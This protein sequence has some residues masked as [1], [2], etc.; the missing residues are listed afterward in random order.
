MRPAA[1]LRRADGDP[2]HRA[3]RPTRTRSSPRR[4]RA[5]APASRRA[6]VARRAAASSLASGRC[7]AA[8][9]SFRLLFGSH[10]VSGL[11]T[12][13]AVDRAHASTSTTGPTRATW[14]SALL[15]ADFLPGGRDRAAARPARRPALAEAAAVGADLVRL[16]VFVAARL[17]GHAG[18]IV[19]LALVAGR[20]HRLRP[21]G[22]LRRAAE[23][24]LRRATSRAR[25]RCC[26]LA[27]Q[28]TIMVGTLLGGVDRRRCPGRI[29]PTGSTRSASGSR[30][31]CSLRIPRGAAPAGP[32]REP[33]ATGRTSGEGFRLVL[34][35]RPLLAVLV[36]WNLAMIAIAFVER[37]RGLPREGLVRRRRLRL[38]PAVGGERPRRGDRR[39]V[40]VHLARAARA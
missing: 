24:R 25:T 6:N 10:L 8:S 1:R 7:S 5:R 39:A 31:C 32:S 33:R 13:L 36:S 38:R 17:R 20:R 11:G 29:S 23:P 16:A 37:V 12:W 2:G 15:I 19:A 40:R 18:Q 34:R 28:L 26:A 27:E 4:S 35:S 9:P 30:P 3:G 22:R 14:V 21:A